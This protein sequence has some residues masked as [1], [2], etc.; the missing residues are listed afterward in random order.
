LDGWRLAN[1]LV[2]DQEGTNIEEEARLEARPEMV[3]IVVDAQQ[4]YA[5]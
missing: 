1:S 2:K 5:S 4:V 3:L